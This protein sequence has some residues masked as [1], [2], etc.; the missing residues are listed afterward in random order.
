M[1]G[2]LLN[3]R[4]TF[5]ANV[6]FI[7]SSD[8]QPSRPSAILDFENLQLPLWACTSASRCKMSLKSNNR[9][10]SYGQKAYFQVTA[11]ILNF[12]NFNF[13]SRDCHLPYLCDSVP[14]LIKIGRFL[15]RDSMHKRGIC[16]HPVSV[17]VSVT[18]VSCAKTNKDI[19][20]IFSP[21]SSHAILV[22][23]RTKRGG[24]ILTGTR[25]TGASNARGV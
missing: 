13:W 8:C 7:R 21:S 11:A 19:F 15:P 24:A 4:H 14:N 3:T 22:F 1:K 6:W 16:R 9:L 23:F 17:C 18:F 2:V 5:P 25:L 10:M 20:E 12:K